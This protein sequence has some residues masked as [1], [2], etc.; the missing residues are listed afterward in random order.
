MSFDS[1]SSSIVATALTTLEILID[2]L[3][4]L[5]IRQFTDW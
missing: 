4:C 3:I 2:Y 5:L 1:A